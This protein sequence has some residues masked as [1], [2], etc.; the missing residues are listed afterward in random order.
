MFYFACLAGGCSKADARLYYLGVRIGALASFK[1][2][3]PAKF[4]HK[5]DDNVFLNALFNELAQKISAHNQNDD[6]TSIDKIL[7]DKLHD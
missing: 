5:L 6:Y 4:I 2:G 3:I 1:S 7:S